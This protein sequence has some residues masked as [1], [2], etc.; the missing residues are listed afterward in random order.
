MTVVKKQ[1]V[2][3]IVYTSAIYSL[4]LEILFDFTDNK[5]YNDNDSITSLV[6][7]IEVSFIS[8]II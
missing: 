8:H 3:Q 1:D 6:H 5:A 4:I 2:T 7:L